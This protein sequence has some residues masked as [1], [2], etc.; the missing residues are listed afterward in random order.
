M[1][2]GFPAYHTEQ[3]LSNSPDLRG[4]V[5]YALSVLGWA[6]KQETQTRITTGTSMNLSSW[7]ETIYIDFQASNML[8]IR[9]ECSLPTQCF[10]WGRNRSNVTK[11][12]TELRKYA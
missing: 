1:A 2:F 7:G 5:R 3:H 9:S 6:I 12:L 4:A 8:S 11:F 10:D